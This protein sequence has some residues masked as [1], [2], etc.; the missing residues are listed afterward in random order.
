MVRKYDVIRMVWWWLTTS[1]VS[2]LCYYIIFVEKIIL[3]DSWMGIGTAILFVL[4][5]MVERLRTLLGLFTTL[6]VYNKRLLT[7]FP[8]PISDS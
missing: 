8:R 3:T 4:Y 6:I 1:L 2:W 7:I 5:I